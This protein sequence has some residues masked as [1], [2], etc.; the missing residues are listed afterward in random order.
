MGA[1]SFLKSKS[2]KIELIL[3]D[4]LG[5][6]ISGYVM[7][8]DVI[9]ALGSYVIEGVGKD[10][11]PKLLDRELIDS[12]IGITDQEAIDMC[13]LL[14]SEEE[15][16]LGGS[17]GLNVAAAI[18]YASTLPKNSNSMIVTIGCD[19]CEKYESKIYNDKWIN[20]NILTK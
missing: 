3:A 14:K 10:S 2:D 6:S 9:S 13:H 11:I 20:Q 8:R 15:I 18:K 7:G 19:S 1:G 5:S 16:Y 4:P 17:S 12:V